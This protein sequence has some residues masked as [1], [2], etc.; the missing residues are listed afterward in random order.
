MVSFNKK[1]TIK[2]KHCKWIN[3]L[4]H[5]MSGNMMS[6]VGPDEDSC[7]TQNCTF[8]LSGDRPEQPS[9]SI[10]GCLRLNFQIPVDKDC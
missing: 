9:Q 1:T 2:T 3:N 6:S 7:F 5:T 4:T 10:C 8:Q